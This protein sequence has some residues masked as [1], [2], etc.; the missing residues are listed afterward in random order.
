[1]S[2]IHRSFYDTIS[3]W[4]QGNWWKLYSR[5]RYQPYTYLE[6]KVLLVVHFF[7]ILYHTRVLI[8]KYFLLLENLIYTQALEEEVKKDRIKS[9]G[10]SNFNM[11]QISTLMECANIPPANLQVEMHLYLQQKE[12]ITFCSQHCIGMTAYAPLGSPGLDQY[13]M[14]NSLQPAR[15]KINLI[16][17]KHWCL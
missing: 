2:A 9:L 6:G 5:S 11:R 16:H 7:K 3:C 4:N 12:L 14:K 15:C 17:N 13:L 1:M 10:L 8:L